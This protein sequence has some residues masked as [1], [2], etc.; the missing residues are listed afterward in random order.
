LLS[1]IPNWLP[2]CFPVPLVSRLAV[3]AWFRLS[4]PLIFLV[5]L[6][7]CFRDDFLDV[8]LLSIISS[9]FLSVFWFRSS[10]DLWWFPG[11][12]RLLIQGG[13]R[14]LVVAPSSRSMMY[15]QFQ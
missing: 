1:I 13:F 3:D 6:F 2:S 12:V 10:L 14:V 7:S 15:L 5:S 4:L 8:C 11:F 9:G